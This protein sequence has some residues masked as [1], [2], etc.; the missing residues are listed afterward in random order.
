MNI[1][2]TL[3]GQTIAFAFFVWFCMKYVWPP[4]MQVLNDRQKKIADGIAAAKRAEQDLALAR[5]KSTAKLREAREQAQIII[6]QANKRATQIVDEAKQQARVEGDRLKAAAEA[7]IEREASLAR[8]ALRNQVAALAV[9]GAERI[10]GEQ[11]DQAANSKLVDD[12]AA[13]L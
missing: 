8:Q 2:A 12:L 1:N 6:D 10:L 9:V 4:L 13:Q 3:I 11:V 5:D 7:E